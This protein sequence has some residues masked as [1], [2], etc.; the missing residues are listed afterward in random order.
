MTN[1]TLP[2]DL[3]QRPATRE[4]AQDIFEINLEDELAEKSESDSTVADV[5]EL[6][7]DQHTNL[8]A[9]TCAITNSQGSLIAYT[10][11]ASTSDG[12]MLDVH[13]KVRRAYPDAA[14]IA[15]YLLAFAEARA[16]VLLDAKSELP[17]TLYTWSYSPAM[18]Q[19]LEQHGYSVASSDYR[20]E[21]TLNEEPPAPRPLEGIIIRPFVRGQEEHALYAVIAE[22]FP[23]ID[24]EPYRPYDDWYQGVFVNRASYDPSMFYVALDGDQAVGTTICRVYPENGDGFIAQVAVRRAWRQRGI[25][26]GLLLTAF[27]EY[28]RRGLRHIL[29]D[30][31][32]ANQTGAHELYRRA[33]MHVQSQANYM[34]KEL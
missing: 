32:T 2:Q 18:T 21:I 17:R 9:D 30:V 34:T 28:Y 25:A 15:A 20:M 16:R 7:D 8:E 22:A 13:T 11:V 23:D 12:I 27:G 6:W 24:G 31:D 5:H 14:N 33:G 3:L 29:L 4:D 26:T 1:I 19:L 10:G